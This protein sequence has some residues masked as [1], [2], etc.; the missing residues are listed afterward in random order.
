MTFRKN[1]LYLFSLSGLI[2]LAIFALVAGP[3]FVKAGT[4]PESVRGAVDD[5]RNNGEAPL[6]EYTDFEWDSVTGF[7]TVPDWI[8]LWRQYGANVGLVIMPVLD[9]GLLLF[10]D[11]GQPVRM[12]LVST[13][14]VLFLDEEPY[15]NQVLIKNGYFSEDAILDSHTCVE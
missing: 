4:A 13:E 12:T 5:S 14:E 6:R 9:T 8:Y 10:C 15:G 11:K 7:Y 1:Y 2:F 3:T